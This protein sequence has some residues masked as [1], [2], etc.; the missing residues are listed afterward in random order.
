MAFWQPVQMVPCTF[1]TRLID[2]KGSSHELLQKSHG[3]ELA[4]TVLLFL[5][6]NWNHKEKDEIKY[7]KELIES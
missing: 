6:F 2:L 3:L 1:H 4:I 7:V 5:V